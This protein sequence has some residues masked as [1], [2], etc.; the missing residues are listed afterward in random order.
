MQDNREWA[1]E[2]QRLQSTLALARAQHE[3]AVQRRQESE[4]AI[5]QAKEDLRENAQPAIA[6][7]HSAQNFEDLIELSQFTS[8]IAE[9]M[10][11][12]QAAEEK[13]AQL[14][15][16]ME[17]PYFARIDFRF[18]DCPGEAERIYIGRTSLM[19][20][21]TYEIVVYDWRSPIA[22]LFYRYGVGPASYQAPRGEIRGEMTRKRQ[23]EIRQGQLQ[24]FF[25]ADVQVVDELLRRMLAQN[26]SPHMKSIV[27]TIQ[28][29]QDAVI[30]DMENDLMMVQ[31]V[32]GSGKTSVALHRAAYLMYQGLAAH[33][34][35]SQIVILSP[36]AVFEQYIDHV[37]PELGEENVTSI[38][39]EALLAKLLHVEQVQPRQQFLETVFTGAPHASVAQHSM[40]WKTS[41]A[42]VQVLDRLIDE[43]PRRWIAF[44]DVFVHGARVADRR[45]LRQKVLSGRKQTP[46]AWKLEQLEEYIATAAGAAH[47]GQLPLSVQERVQRF[48]RVDAAELYRWFI[49]DDAVFSR[50]TQGVQLP[51]DIQQILTFTRENLD[52]HMMA[53]DDAA[54]IA[55]LSLRIHGVE[56]RNIRQV[57]IDEAQD[58]APLHYE[59]LNLLFPSAK[60]TVL[61]DVNQTLEGPGDLSLYTQIEAIFHKRRASLIVLDQSFRCT[62]EILAYSAHFLA[63]RG[64]VRSFNRSGEVPQVHVAA[65]AQALCEAIVQQAQQ[66]LAMGY[67]SVG[68]LCKSQHRADALYAQLCAHLPVRH[69]AADG[70]EEL[71]GVC[72]LPIYLSKGLEFDAVILCDADAQTYCSEDDRRLLYIACTRA[73]HRLS[74]LCVGEASPLLPS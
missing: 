46:L 72:L 12:A 19:R 60:F 36:N 35:A 29:G 65:N 66:C 57:V 30:R 33:L 67:R 71:Q 61:G 7:L 74:L 27:E 63:H 43:A 64:E 16:V 28:R 37:L 6:G 59:V 5:R 68:L 3:R 31:G 24:Y 11:D 51:A 18:A 53:G 17:A 26:A 49:C 15:R 4:R 2:T 73:L 34:T 40:A 1:E 48:T 58:Y 41:A 42:F 54:A 69:I 10:A 23:Y 50:L 25:D 8:P 14:Q 13:I 21:Q 44:A 9:K 32:A 62:Q 45:T 22:G 20:E 39:W 38:V 70:E 52:A 56:D 55:Y 47:F